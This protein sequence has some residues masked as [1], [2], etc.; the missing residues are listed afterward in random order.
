MRLLFKLEKLLRGF[1]KQPAAAQWSLCNTEPNIG[2]QRRNTGRKIRRA[3]PEIIERQRQYGCRAQFEIRPQQLALC[4]A[5]QLRQVP[6]AIK[7]VSHN[8]RTLRAA[9]TSLF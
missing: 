4:A 8:R 7:K 5:A 3:T 2:Y 9:F 1:F 6:P